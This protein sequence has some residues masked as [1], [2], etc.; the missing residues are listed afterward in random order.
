MTTTPFRGA[1][2]ATFPEELPETCIKAGTKEG[3]IVLDPF[4]GS[5]TTG[6]VAKRLKRDWIGIEL[7]SDYAD[8]ARK[9]LAGFVNWFI[10]KD[11]KEGKQRTL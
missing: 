7:N 4:F 9:R 8:I 11:I 2:F 6:V 10:L 3:D 1:H 5:G